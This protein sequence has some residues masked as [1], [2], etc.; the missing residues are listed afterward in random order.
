MGPSQ[1]VSAIAAMPSR[2]LVSNTAAAKQNLITLRFLEG[3][4]GGQGDAE[5]SRGRRE[6]TGV[7]AGQGEEAKVVG[8]QPS[9]TPAGQVHRTAERKPRLGLRC[10]AAGSAVYDVRLRLEN[11]AMSDK[12]MLDRKNEEAHGL[13]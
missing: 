3:F 6:A 10:G 2:A 4:A 5:C 12:Q 1:I 11:W 8:P 9:W 7:L 13:A